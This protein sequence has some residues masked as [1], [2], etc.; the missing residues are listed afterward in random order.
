[1]YILSAGPLMLLHSPSRLKP[2][3][4]GEAEKD[5]GEIL[6]CVSGL[7]LSCTFHLS[8]TGKASDISRQKTNSVSP[9]KSSV[10]ASQDFFSPPFLLSLPASS[11]PSR[12]VFASFPWMRYCEGRLHAFQTITVHPPPP[13]QVSSSARAPHMP[14][15]PLQSLKPTTNVKHLL[16]R[17]KRGGPSAGPPV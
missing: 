14:A 6:W 17:Q 15:H 4:K 9:V 13:P 16:R 10:K 11:S 12:S 7:S 8:L 5:A 3:E 2:E 1:M